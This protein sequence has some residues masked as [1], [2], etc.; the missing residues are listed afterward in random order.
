M[1]LSA[2]TFSWLICFSHPLYLTT[3]SVPTAAAITYK[4]IALLTLFKHTHAH[5]SVFDAQL[6]AAADGFNVALHRLAQ[7]NFLSKCR[8][9]AQTWLPMCY[10]CCLLFMHAYTFSSSVFNLLLITQS[11]PLFFLFFLKNPNFIII[12]LLAPLF[13]LMC[14]G[15]VQ[16]RHSI[17]QAIM[18]PKR[19]FFSQCF[20]SSVKPAWSN[21]LYI[22]DEQHKCNC[23]DS[24][25][26]FIWIKRGNNLLTCGLHMP[27]TSC[28]GTR[29]VWGSLIII[30]RGLHHSAFESTPIALAESFAVI[31]CA[32]NCLVWF[33]F[34]F[35]TIWEQH[36]FGD[37][38]CINS[39][40]D[41]KIEIR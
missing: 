39:H 4:L 25:E 11:L 36:E 31:C 20:L 2:N 22:T 18:S 33:L 27:Y 7:A 28:G 15:D 1:V 41:R 6:L 38:V 5:S 8:W 40:P 13:P 21:M 32:T 14:H 23:K 3:L 12:P 17:K 16:R 34:S 29:T 24:S 37:G 10:T 19:F 35:F 9:W 30:I 26:S